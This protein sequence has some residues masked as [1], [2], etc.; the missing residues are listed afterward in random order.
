MDATCR[1]PLMKALLWRAIYHHGSGHFRDD[2]FGNVMEHFYDSTGITIL[3]AIKSSWMYMHDRKRDLLWQ[4][5]IITEVYFFCSARAPA[6][7][8]C[9][10]NFPPGGGNHHHRSS[11]REG[12]NPLQKNTLPRWYVFV[13]VGRVFCHA[14]TSMTNL[15]QNEDSHT[16]VV[17]EW[18]YQN[19]HHGSVHFH[20][21]K[22]RVTEVLSSRVTDTWHPP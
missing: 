17:V 2:N 9:R 4:T 3:I 12:V 14:C 10:G 22:S 15:W 8:F 21:D 7:L 16:C 11:H 19:Y 13:T 1:S 6:E 5:R 18:H 20:D